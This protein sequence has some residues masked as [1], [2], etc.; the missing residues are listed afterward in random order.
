MKQK[1]H[2]TNILSIVFVLIIGVLLIL[3]IAVIIWG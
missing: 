1:T 3:G 2:L